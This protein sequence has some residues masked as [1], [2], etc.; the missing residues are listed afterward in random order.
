MASFPVALSMTCENGFASLSNKCALSINSTLM[1][2]CGL[3][4]CPSATVMCSISATRR[5]HDQ[6]VTVLGSAGNSEASVSQERR[7]L[8]EVENANRKLDDLRNAVSEKLSLCTVARARTATSAQDSVPLATHGPPKSAED[9]KM[10]S[11]AARM[12]SMVKR[13][14]EATGHG[15]DDLLGQG[16]SSR[17]P[18]ARSPAPVWATTSHALRPTSRCG[19][20]QS[21]RVYLSHETAGLLIER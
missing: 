18:T 11:N 3:C 12:S 20:L 8:E 2:L 15:L 7:I 16:G 9:M 21:T 17:V 6:T 13:V 5:T 10:N 14:V 1:L 19:T 4:Y